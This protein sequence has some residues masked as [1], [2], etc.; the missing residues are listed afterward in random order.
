VSNMVTIKRNPKKHNEYNVTMKVTAGKILAI[1]NALQATRT[2]V[3]V[4]ILEE[5]EN[6]CNASGERDL[7]DW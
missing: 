7:Q 3:G 6:A 2:P 4:D 1:K 5:I